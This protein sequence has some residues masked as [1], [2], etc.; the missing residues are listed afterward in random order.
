LGELKV[1]FLSGLLSSTGKINPPDKSH[2]GWYCIG[3]PTEASFAVLAMKAGFNLG[4][5]EGDY[6]VIKYFAFDSFRKRAAI[7]RRHKNKVISFV[8]G[9]LES[10]LDV[11]IKI[12]VNGRI[13]DLSETTKTGN[14]VEVSCLCSKRIADY[15]D[16]L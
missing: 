2:S 1:F 9:S 3:D 12:I 16:R 7:I 10:V 8:K 5:V 14:S 11:S 4:E 13:E 6:P 15:C